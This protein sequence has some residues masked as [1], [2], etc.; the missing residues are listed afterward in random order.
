MIATLL[1]LGKYLT[2]VGGGPSGIYVDLLNL[3]WWQ[4]LVAIVGILG[5]SPA[6][7]LTGLALNRIQFAGPARKD[8]E[9]QM[10]EKDTVHEKA[11]TEQARHYEALL[12][13]HRTRYDDL[14]KSNSIHEERADKLTD[15]AFQMTEVVKANSHVMASLNEVAR[16]QAGP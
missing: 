10:T 14:D 12:E 8:F 5:L 9:R 4:G 16:E 2:D 15:A 1:I 11:L 7:W 3:Q 6:P 13:F